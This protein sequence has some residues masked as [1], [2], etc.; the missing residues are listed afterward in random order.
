LD[1]TRSTVEKSVATRSS[2]RA[3]PDIDLGSDTK[4]ARRSLLIDVVRGLAISLVVLGHT[5]Q[6][7]AHRGWWGASTVGH[8]LQAFIYAFHMPAFFFVS[9]VF[10]NKSVEKRGMLH[11]TLGKLRTILYPYILW[12][13]VYLLASVL[14]SR[15]MLQTTPSFHTFLYN[16]ATGEGGWF[17]PSLF[18]CLMLGMLGRR[19]SKPFFFLLTIAALFWMPTTSISFVDRGIC[20]LPFLTLGMWI[21]NAYT[22]FERLSRPAAALTSASLGFGLGMMT[23]RFSLDVGFIFLAFGTLGTLLLLLAA[24]VVGHSAL[25]RGLAWIGQASFGVFLMAPFPQGAGRALLE[26]LRITSPYPQ[27]LLPTLLAVL[28]PAWIYHHRM[29]LR[30]GW[31]FVSPR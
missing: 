23:L 20:E 29:R 25:A 17:L 26:G 30:L 18:F 24:T 28:I 21:G 15:F 27:L 4:P 7:I 22:Q 13:C 5:N 19:V 9:G 6:G 3:E 1:K 11:F 16:L 10:L 2:L 31:L 14:F 8:D 12:T